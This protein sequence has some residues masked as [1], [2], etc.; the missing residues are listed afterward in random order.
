M[1]TELRFV[2]RFGERFGPYRLRADSERSYSGKIDFS[3]FKS[4]YNIGFQTTNINLQKYVC[5]I[6]R[7]FLI[8]L[9]DR[10][11]KIKICYLIC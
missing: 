2:A 9:E 5:R 11:H 7:I 8:L 1:D 4:R 6:K 10:G 3:D